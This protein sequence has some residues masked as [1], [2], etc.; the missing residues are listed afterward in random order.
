MPQPVKILVADDEEKIGELLSDFLSED[1]YEVQSFCYSLDA[2]RALKS[3][4]YDLLLTDLKMPVMNGLEL[5]IRARRI[6]PEL[7]VVVVTGYASVDSV[8]EALRAGVDDYITKPFEIDDLR[9]VIQRALTARN[10]RRENQ[11]LLEQLKH[12]NLSLVKARNELSEQITL[13]QAS[14][15][16]TNSSLERRL[17]EL[18]MLNDVSRVV[19]SV[20]DLD[21][22][23]EVYL[24]LV[25]TKT[26]IRNASVMLLEEGQLTVRAASGDFAG[27]LTGQQI[28]LGTGIEGWV[29]ENRIPVLVDDLGSDPRFQGSRSAKYSSG[30]FICVPLM[31]K[32]RLL[33]VL[34][35]NDKRSG[36]RLSQNDLKLLTTLASQ[37]SVALENARLY[38]VLQEN[39][40]RTVQAL[41]FSLEA[42]DHYTSGHSA[43]VTEYAVQVANRMG[44][45]PADVDQLRYAGQLHDVGKIGVSEAILKKPASL[46]E[47]EYQSIQQHPVIGE[48]IIEPLEFLGQVG[49]IIRSHHERWDGRGYPDGLKAHQIPRLTRIMTIADSYDAMT[50][51]RPYRSAKSID[52]A[53]HEITR[54]RGTQFDPEVTDV[55]LEVLRE[56]ATLSPN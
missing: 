18:S 41:A 21:K 49:S 16:E 11:L 50:S 45:T 26:G 54:C 20:L 33:G 31:V 2:L 38:H 39:A 29:A 35:V 19:S 44:L 32:G 34:D 3:A 43:R 55:F 36:E 56:G 37:V 22:L 1:G 28:P 53:V 40:L 25:S 5:A 42:K 15:T 14:L 12:A 46:T 48:R 17:H 9:Q 52:E 8:V 10:I 30:S 51:E 27:K 6:D 4:R 24:E 13:A 7:V 47:D 23:L